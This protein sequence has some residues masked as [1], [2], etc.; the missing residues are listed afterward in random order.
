V[1]DERLTR[2]REHQF[3]GWRP[4]LRQLARLANER[5]QARAMLA[6]A[7]AAGHAI[8]AWARVQEQVSQAED[9]MVALSGAT[10]SLLPWTAVYGAGWE[11]VD[12]LWAH[13]LQNPANRL[14]IRAPDQPVAAAP[15][16]PGREGGAGHH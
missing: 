7:E 11:Q 8:V 12:P 10:P 15:A 2:W 3:P 14:H 4:S 16:R 5:E 6:A 9:D 1:R 13:T